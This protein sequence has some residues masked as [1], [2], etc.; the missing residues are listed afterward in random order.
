MFCSGFLRLGKDDREEQI[1]NRRDLF[2]PSVK[3]K[4]GAPDSPESPRSQR[5]SKMNRASSND[6]EL[7]EK[8]KRRI[9]YRK[10]YSNTA[11]EEQ[12]DDDMSQRSLNEG[13]QKYISRRQMTAFQE[14]VNG[15]TDL[16][17]AFFIIFYVLSGSWLTSS[18]IETVRNE[19]TD[20]IFDDEGCISTSWLPHFHALPPYAVIA[21]ALATL[22]HGPFSF[23]YHYKYA[24]RLPMEE[25]IGHWSRRMDQ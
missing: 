6:F 5:R 25:R 13:A 1:S 10:I 9:S 23:I 2:V 8:G 22:F 3:I 14:R 24:H 12:S 7:A 20:E 4:N 17:A 11:K 21:V 19:A 18:V 16:P 15:L